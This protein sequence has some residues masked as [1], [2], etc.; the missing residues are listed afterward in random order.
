MQM[1]RNSRGV[2]KYCR[3]LPK[4]RAESLGTEAQ[5][6]TPLTAAALTGFFLTAAFSDHNTVC[7]DH[8]YF[9][10]QFVFNHFLYKKDELCIF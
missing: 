4:R 5:G 3:Y 6:R 1:S 2:V 8:V 9:F 10:V 7:N